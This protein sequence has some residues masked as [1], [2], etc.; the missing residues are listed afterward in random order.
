MAAGFI[1]QSGG[2]N[3]FEID[4]GALR[5]K[6]S[7]M[8]DEGSTPS[9]EVVETPATP[10]PV[11]ADPSKVRVKGAS[12]GQAPEVAKTEEATVVDTEN[13]TAQQMAELKDDDLVTVPVDGKDEVMTWKE[14]RAGFSRTSK[15]TKS[16]QQLARDKAEFEPKVARL[17]QLETERA[18]LESFLNNKEAVL[19]YVVQTFGADAFNAATGAAQLPAANGDEIVTHSEAQQL[20]AAKTA[21]LEEQIKTVVKGVEDRIAEA[22]KEIEAKREIAAHSIVINSTLTDIFTANPVLKSIPRAEELIRYEV[23]QLNPQTEGEAL[24][25]FRQVAQGMVEDIGQHFQAQRKIQ[26][27]TAAKQKLESKS[28]EPAGGSAPQPAPTNYKNADGSVNWKAVTA[29]AKDSF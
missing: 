19:K 23:A 24:A 3:T 8:M 29:M 21:T 22:T 6:A 2:K 16:M 10:A 20:V 18:G 28:I 5:E 13:A 26:V 12:E 14:A 7:A 11:E 9:P 17:T 1:D 25:A 4:F 27:V 15:F